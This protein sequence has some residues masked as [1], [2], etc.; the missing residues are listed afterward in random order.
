MLKYNERVKGASDQDINM[1]EVYF[2]QSIPT[3]YRHF[4]KNSDGPSVYDDETDCEFQFF[5]VR[6]TIDYFGEK[7]KESCPSA[8]P[9]CKDSKGNVAVY[10]FEHT[11][12]DGIYVMSSSEIDWDKATGIGKTI[13][14]LLQIN[15]EAKVREKGVEVLKD[16]TSNLD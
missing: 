14:D 6:Q 9:I 4:L 5:S 10:R 7:L 8:I 11:I 16:R 1:W 2:S 3:D 13:Q 12:Y 15:I